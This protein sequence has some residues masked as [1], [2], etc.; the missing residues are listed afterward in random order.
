MDS[1]ECAVQIHPL[2]TIFR[3][4]CRTTCDREVRTATNN[5]VD[6]TIMAAVALIGFT[7]LEVGATAATPVWVTLTLFGLNHVI[8][9]HATHADEVAAV[10]PVI[11]K[12]KRAG[13]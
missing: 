13:L 9:M 12:A 2:K 1:C 6:L 4:H 3:T 11:V 8:E 5:N 10:A 7:V